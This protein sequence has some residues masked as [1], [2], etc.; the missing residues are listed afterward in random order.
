MERGFQAGDVKRQ[1]TV[2]GKM[3]IKRKE[4]ETWSKRASDNRKKNCRATEEKIKPPQ[5]ND[6]PKSR[7][8]SRRKSLVAV[9]HECVC[10]C[11]W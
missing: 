7:D 3:T 6:H 2:G 1:S 10:T 11:M 8:R 9:V 5:K 4:I